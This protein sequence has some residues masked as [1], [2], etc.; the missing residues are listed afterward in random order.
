VDK[1]EA[2]VAAERR[3]ARAVDVRDLHMEPD[4]TLVKRG[5]GVGVA[6]TPTA[7]ANLGE[8]LRDFAPA[9]TAA[10]G[11]GAPGAEEAGDATV[12]MQ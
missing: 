1:L 7:L 4:G 5:N 3:T 6:M 9:G 12:S 10:D 2:R 8:F 11:S